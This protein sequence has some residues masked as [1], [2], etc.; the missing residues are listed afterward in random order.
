MSDI[1]S[2]IAA[3]IEEQ[4][5]VTKDIAVNIGEASTGV[6][7]ANVRVAESSQAT[8]DIAKEIA[9]VDQPRARWRRAANRFRPARPTSRNWPGNSSPP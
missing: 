3:A 8:E 5:T 7:D 4:A 1:V 6:Q 9:G 2:S